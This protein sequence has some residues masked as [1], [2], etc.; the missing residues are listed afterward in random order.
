M[1]SKTLPAR[2][3]WEQWRLFEPALYYRLE[4][5]RRFYWCFG[6]LFEKNKGLTSTRTNASLAQTVFQSLKEGHGTFE[7]KEA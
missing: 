2:E 5:G 6:H 7:P 1:I 4:D 3:Q